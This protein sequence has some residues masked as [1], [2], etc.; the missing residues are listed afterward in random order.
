MLILIFGLSSSY[1]STFMPPVITVFSQ[2]KK[3]KVSS[4]YSY[5]QYINFMKFNC[6]IDFSFLL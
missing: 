1:F 2:K 4:V 6:G 5:F 3:K